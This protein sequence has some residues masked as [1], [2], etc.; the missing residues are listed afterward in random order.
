MDEAAVE[1]AGPPHPRRPHASL[2]RKFGEESCRSHHAMMG[3]FVGGGADHPVE[4]VVVVGVVAGG[5]AGEAGAA[6]VGGRRGRGIR[7]E[8]QQWHVVVQ[9]AADEV[10]GGGGGG[11]RHLMIEPHLRIFLPR[12]V[13]EAEER[14]RPVRVDRYPLDRPQ[15]VGFRLHVVMVVVVETTVVRVLQLRPPTSTSSSSAAA[16]IEGLIEVELLIRRVG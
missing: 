1:G 12:R 10:G 16:A 5:D 11:I 7:A 6:A 4:I 14:E 8:I 9:A 15:A 13:V 3:V 2:R